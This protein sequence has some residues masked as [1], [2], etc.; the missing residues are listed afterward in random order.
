MNCDFILGSVAKEGAKRQSSSCATN[1]R[2]GQ[3]TLKDSCTLVG[4]VLLFLD[5]L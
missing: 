2:S 4:D 1:S 5:R 3:F